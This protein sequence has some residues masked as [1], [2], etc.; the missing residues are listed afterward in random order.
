[1]LVV[2]AVVLGLAAPLEAASLRGSR[3]SMD[4]QNR[5]ARSHQLTF[6]RDSA[7]VRRAVKDKTL[8]AVSGNQDYT[9][10]DPWY[11]YALPDTRLF[12]EQLAREYRAA[13]GEQLVVTSLVR[14]KNR[15][16]RNA[17]PRTV[18]PTGMAFDLRRSRNATCRGWLER[19]LLDLEDVGI[20]EGNEERYPP[21]YHVALFPK[22]YRTYLAAAQGHDAP[23]AATLASYKVRP[24]D[25]LWGI[26]RRHGV[27]VDSLRAANSIASAM[28][29]PGQVLSIPRR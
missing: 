1:V 15:Q 13:C 2:L 4:R 25:S 27:T 28:L 10:L 5:A 24:G 12:I 14:P 9:L 29:R 26:A 19:T 20:L 18:H 21:H 8:V 23:E 3:T 11:P 6:L 7:A 16:P 17:S 22:P